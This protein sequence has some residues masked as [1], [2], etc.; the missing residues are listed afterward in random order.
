MC[1][2]YGAMKT[3]LQILIVSAALAFLAACATTPPPDNHN[4]NQNYP[5]FPRGE[6]HGSNNAIPSNY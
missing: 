3:T 1:K 4:G 5:G 6:E 2:K